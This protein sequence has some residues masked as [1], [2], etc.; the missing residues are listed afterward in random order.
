M[1]LF[2]HVAQRQTSGFDGLRGIPSRGC[3]LQLD[4]VEEMA[5]G[6]QE[7]RNHEA[8]RRKDGTTYDPRTPRKGRLRP[9]KLQL[10]HPAAVSTCCPFWFTEK[11]ICAVAIFTAKTCFVV[12]CLRVTIVLIEVT[13]PRTAGALIGPAHL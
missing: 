5:G 2:F 11:G 7:T 10:I 8:S 1:F 13:R 3:A 12:L 9:V 6:R 4:I